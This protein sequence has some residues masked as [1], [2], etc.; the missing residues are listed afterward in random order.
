MRVG[1]TGA[2]GLVGRALIRELLGGGAEDAGAE[3]AGG[4]PA[5]WRVTALTRSDA[6][7]AGLPAEVETA[8][9]DPLGGPPGGPLGGPDAALDRAL[10]ELD[11]VVH[12]AGEPVGKRWTA[13]RKRRI[14][15]SRL[16][17][18]ATLV[19][20]L[21]RVRAGS[22]S[23][24]SDSGGSDSG[25]SDSPGSDSPGSD[26][27]AG[28]NGGPT[29]LLA[30]S[31]VGYYGARGDEELDEDAAPGEGFLT[32]VCLAWEA[33][34]AA[35]REHGVET[36]SL[37]LGLVLAPDGGALAR[38]LPPFRFGLGGRLGDGRQ[39][40]PW[41]HLEDVARAF[42]SLLEAPAGSLA[43][44]YNLTAPAPATNAE[45]TRALGRA[46]RRPTPFPAPGF[47]LRLA[48]GE[49]ADALL[50]SGQR[51]VP[52]RLLDSGFDFRHRSLDAALES[53]LGRR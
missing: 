46:L 50:L 17:G 37:R 20:A 1:I 53:L 22:D 3:D 52:K 36:A 11:A 39:W 42:R 48:L 44:T 31:A 35:A 4:A 43:P 15:E 10:G 21:G 18:T 9:W 47:A 6:R 23:G 2:T 7:P 24:G 33:E 49:M 32:E 51:A 5:G 8:R 28:A 14:R 27:P 12:L 41:I 40:M 38:M 29:R 25:G 16:R 34:T 26:S 13:E 45:F 19:A 30:A